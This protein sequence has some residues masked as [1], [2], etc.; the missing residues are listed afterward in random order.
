MF[1]CAHPQR[2]RSGALHDV[3]QAMVALIDGVG[4]ST[5]AVVCLE[6]CRT[7]GQSWGGMVPTRAVVEPLRALA[8]NFGSLVEL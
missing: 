5:S 8:R 4:T 2:R 1:P 7:H 3:L 6:Q